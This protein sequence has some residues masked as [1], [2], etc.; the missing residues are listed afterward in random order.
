MT[1]QWRGAWYG[2]VDY[3]WRFEVSNLG[4]MRNK[5]R[6]NVYIP[7]VGKNGYLKI[8]TSIYGRNKNIYIHRCVAE[9]FLPNPANWSLVNHLDGNKQ[10]NRSDNLEWSTP[11]ENYRHAVR[12]CLISPESVERFSRK[13]QNGCDNG[14][15]KL[16]ESVVRYIRANYVP[17]SRGQK[18][19]RRELAKMFGVSVGLISQIVNRQIWTH[20]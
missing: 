13:V 18:C 19:N 4:R 9:T 20:I 6:K 12:M 10:N 2:G 16:T 11:K 15:A 17:K 8:C 7:Y 1:E 14:R 5:V 3:S